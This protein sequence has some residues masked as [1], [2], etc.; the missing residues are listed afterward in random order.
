[1][2]FT[3][4][5]YIRLVSGLK[6][7]TYIYDDGFE[8]LRR[9]YYRCTYRN[10]QGC[11]ATKH[12]QRSDADLAVFD[13]TYQGAH[14]CHQKPQ[15]HADAAAAA[16]DG[17][18]HPP[19]QDPDVQ[20]LASSRSGLKVETDTLPPPSSSFHGHD[21]SVAAFSF[22]YAPAAGFSPMDSAGH[23][24]LTARGGCFSAAPFLSPAAT[25]SAG[26]GYFSA[27]VHFPAV[28]TRGAPETSELGEVVSAAT[29]SAAAAAAGRF[30]YSLYGYQLHDDDL[31]SFAP[32]FGHPSSAGQ[33]GDA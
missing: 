28:G 2:Y 20:L 16:R 8:S 15:R 18:H 14:T 32:M 11:P 12:V 30:D 3:S 31:D 27:A 1:M 5:L 24:Q 10:A 29:S 26:S 17:G 25:T 22:P 21:V 13:V 4:A 7:C 33:H 9:G 23:E 19:W 6:P